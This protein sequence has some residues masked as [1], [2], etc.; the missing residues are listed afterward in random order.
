L[1]ADGDVPVIFFNM[2][3]GNFYFEEPYFHQKNLT[4]DNVTFREFFKGAL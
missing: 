2:P 3:N 1:A 4:K